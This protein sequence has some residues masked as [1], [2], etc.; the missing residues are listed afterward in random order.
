MGEEV[1]AGL[2]PA[3][4]PAWGLST[5]RRWPGAPFCAKWLRELPLTPTDFTCMTYRMYTCY[6]YKYQMKTLKKA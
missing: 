4:S 5:D 2:R 6:C 3:G 1:A